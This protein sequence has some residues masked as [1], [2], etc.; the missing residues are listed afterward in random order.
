MKYGIIGSCF[1]SVVLVGAFATAARA[2]ECDKQTYLTFRAP[3]SLPSMVLPAGTYLFSHLECSTSS[4]IL[5]ITSTD[6]SRL[7]RDTP[8]NPGRIGRRQVTSRL[9]SWQDARRSTEAHQGVVLPGCKGR[10]QAGLSEGLCSAERQAQR[11]YPG[12]RLAMADRIVDRSIN[13]PIREPARCAAGSSSPR[14]IPRP[15][16]FR[17]STRRDVPPQNTQ[18]TGEPSATPAPCASP[19]AACRGACWPARMTFCAPS[20]HRTRL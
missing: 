3:V 5:R 11:Q 16:W 15:R 20:P 12:W 10:G 18:I 8:G 19:G 4:N 9:L 17:L 7:C 2:G 14:G 13:G 1:L 6:G